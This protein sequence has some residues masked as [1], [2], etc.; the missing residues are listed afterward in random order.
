MID[1]TKLKESDV[2]RWVKYKGYAKSDKGRILSWAKKWVFVV[3]NCDDKWDDFK[4]YQGVATG[5]EFLT[6]M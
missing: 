3:Y 1:I 4:D 2:G 5:P 6:F